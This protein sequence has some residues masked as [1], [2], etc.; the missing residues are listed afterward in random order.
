MPVHA[1]QSTSQV[2]QVASFVAPQAAVWYWPAP[3]TV[4]VAQVASLEPP[5]AAVWYVP[6][7]HVEHVLHAVSCVGVQALAWNWPMP[8]VEQATHALPTRWNPGAHAEQ[9]VA[10][11]QAAQPAGQAAQVVFVVAVQAAVWY[12]PAA[13]V[14]QALHATPSPV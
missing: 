14:V 13:Q 1:V 4:Q 3:Q 11:L 2:A 10:S 8:H 12:C 7:P 5:Q 6:A 9:V